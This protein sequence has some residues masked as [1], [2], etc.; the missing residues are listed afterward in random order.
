MVAKIAKQVI[1]D[2]PVDMTIIALGVLAANIV[3]QLF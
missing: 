3:T 2:L 1:K